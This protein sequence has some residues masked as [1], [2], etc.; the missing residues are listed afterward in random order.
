MRR[1]DK[2]HLELP[3]AGSRMLRDLPNDQGLPTRR[4]HVATLMQQ[5]RIFA[6]G[7]SMDR[8]GGWRDNVFIVRLWKSVKYE[9][10]YRVP[11]RRSITR[12]SCSAAI[13]A[14]IAPPDRTA[15]LIGRR[16]TR[17]TTH[18]RLCPRRFESSMESSCP[19]ELGC[20]NERDQLRHSW[21]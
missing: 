5:M 4:R 2:L 21:A 19:I 14:S 8:S 1:I 20:S 7:I 18:R 15:L 12:N 13:L 17:S 11:T 16:R 9:N 6:F 10:V 3:F